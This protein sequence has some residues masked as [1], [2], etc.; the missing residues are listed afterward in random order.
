M[1]YGRASK[2]FENLFS[3]SLSYFS[4]TLWNFKN[5]FEFYNS[6]GGFPLD[7]INLA[8]VQPWWTAFSTIS[9]YKI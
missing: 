9:D 5:A 1:K 6:K 2:P 8:T 4:R 7:T 3:H